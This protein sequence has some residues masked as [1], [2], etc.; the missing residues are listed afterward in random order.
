MTVTQVF[1]VSLLFKKMK[2]RGRGRL[3][4]ILAER[5]GVYSGEGAY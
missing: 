3:F 5:V 2:V 1:L 4:A